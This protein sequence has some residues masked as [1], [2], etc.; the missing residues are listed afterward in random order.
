MVLDAEE[1]WDRE[2]TEIY[3]KITCEHSRILD[4]YPRFVALC[5]SLSRFAFHEIYSIITPYALRS[6][7]WSKSKMNSPVPASN[8]FA[9]LKRQY[10]TFDFKVALQ[11]S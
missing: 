5:I 10:H 7:W 3:F 11:L 1:S 4:Q 9:S 8:M 2:L 6:G